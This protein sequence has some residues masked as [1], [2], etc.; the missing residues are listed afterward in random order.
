M[1]LCAPEGSR[2]AGWRRGGLPYRLQTPEL[3]LA[4]L[5]TPAGVRGPRIRWGHSVSRG[6]A[7]KPDHWVF[8]FL[9]CLMFELGAK[10]QTNQLDHL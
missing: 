6:H 5:V 7:P 4:S 1:I 9:D 8:N 10:R 3:D 2:K